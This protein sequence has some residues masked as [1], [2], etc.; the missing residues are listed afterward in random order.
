MAFW[1]AVSTEVAGDVA[2][3][4]ADAL[5]ECGAIAV[6]VSDAAAGTPHETPAFG[7]AVDAPWQW[8]NVSALIDSEVD[9]AVMM[10]AALEYAGLPATAAFRVVRVDDQDWV[11]ATQRQFGPVHVS[12]RLWIVPSWHQP[13][14]PAAIN[15]LLDPGAAFGTGTH[16]T[17]RLCLR[18]LEA[19]IK[20]GETLLDYGCGSGIL[21]I[22][23]CKFG[24]GD[25]YG[26]DIDPQAV[27]AANHNAGQ[28]QVSVRFFS[29]AQQLP[30]D[31]DI[32]VA[33]ILATP[34]KVLAPIVA[35]HTGSGGRIALSGILAGQ[36]AELCDIYGRW[37]DMEPAA[38]ATQ[39][40]GWVL[41][42]GVKR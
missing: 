32:V 41:L 21:A 35:R 39:D 26:V 20:G 12:Q 34:L 23:A 37:F 40:E 7:D 15:I 25:V 11:R 13:P 3:A 6:D 30:L 14:D 16:P 29:A 33:N 18:W 24:A 10:P 36:A 19:Q 5:L 31:L 2:D 1:L 9:P 42:S 38:A 4:L 27:V 8:A 17:T 28:N 22:A